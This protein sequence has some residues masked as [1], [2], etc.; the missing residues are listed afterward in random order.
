MARA[1]RGWW[2][3]ET[4]LGECKMESRNRGEERPRKGSTWRNRRNGQDYEVLMVDH[5]GVMA[6]C[7]FLMA[8]VRMPVE[9]FKEHFEE[10]R[11]DC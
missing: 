6:R 2:Q 4:T 11:D 5:R 1:L 8:T 9:K 3:N 10:V 7:M